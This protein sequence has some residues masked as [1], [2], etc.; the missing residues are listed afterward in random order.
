MAWCCDTYPSIAAKALLEIVTKCYQT[1][2]LVFPL[3]GVRQI[4]Q[5]CIC[6]Y[7]VLLLSNRMLCDGGRDKSWYCPLSSH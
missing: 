3:C 6:L 1:A 7:R 4:V 5:V 2:L